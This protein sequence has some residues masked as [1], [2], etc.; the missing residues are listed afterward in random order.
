M[1]VNEKKLQR[2]RMNFSQTAKGLCQMDCT[3]EFGTPEECRS[4][5]GEAIDSLRA[6]LVSKGLKEVGE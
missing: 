6:V 5:M 3:V 2:V 1:E 4:A